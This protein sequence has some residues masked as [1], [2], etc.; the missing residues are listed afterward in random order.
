MRRLLLV[1][2]LLFLSGVLVACAGGGG[3]DSTPDWAQ[4]GASQPPT[5]DPAAGDVRVP[6]VP[7]PTPTPST[8]YRRLSV[9]AADGVR[10]AGLFYPPDTSPAPG[11]L[12]LHMAE[13]QKEDWVFLASRLQEAGYGVLVVDLRGHGE[14]EGEM[15]WVAMPDDAVRSW[16]ALLAQPEVD[17]ARCAVVGAGLGANLALVTATADPGVSAVVMLSPGLEDHGV[18]TEEAIAAYGE[19]PALIVASQDDLYAAESSLTLHELA[20]TPPVLMLYPSAGHGTEMLAR[21]PDLTALI[22]SWLRA[23]LGP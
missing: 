16:A 3:G 13:R 19:R 17:S 7:T 2:C 4:S 20:Q 14:S 18:G 8:N 22:V 6:S 23:Q 11:I 10:L 12:L 5:G 21:Q 9:T 15:D 1:G